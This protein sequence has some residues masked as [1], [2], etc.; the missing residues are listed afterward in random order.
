MQS[1][2]ST[3]KIENGNKKLENV[4]DYWYLLNATDFKVVLQIAIIEKLLG[5]K[6]VVE[7]N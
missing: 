1:K 2:H 7:E 6:D 3:L 5:G 4:S